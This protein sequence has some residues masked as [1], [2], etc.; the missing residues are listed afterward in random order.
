M[1]SFTNCNIQ[2]D[3][4]TNN[5]DKSELEIA[6]IRAENTL[7]DKI[8]ELE[9]MYYGMMCDYPQ[10]ATSKDIKLYESSIESG[11][12]IPMDSL[13]VNVVASNEQLT[14]PFELD[15]NTLKPE[16]I[17]T[18]S[19]YKNKVKWVS[20]GGIIYNNRVFQYSKCTIKNKPIND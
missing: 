3:K 7:T 17:F 9:L 1:I 6:E 18:G 5:R 2:Y 8:E 19:F 11:N 15:Y 10:W 14:N 4:Q 16:F 12:P 13:F 20:D